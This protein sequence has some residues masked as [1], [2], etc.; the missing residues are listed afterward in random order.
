MSEVRA[1]I[2]LSSSQSQG[3]TEER[4]IRELAGRLRAEFG[5][6]V[7]FGLDRTVP[8]GVP[9]DVRRR[10]DKTEYFILVDFNLDE[11]KE[12]RRNHLWNRSLFAHQEFAIAVYLGLD[13]LAFFEKGLKEPDGIWRYVVKE[14]AR[15]FQRRSL[16]ST[17]LSAVRTQTRMDDSER[18]WSPDWRRELTMSRSTVGTHN[19]GWVQ[20]G[21]A[22]Q[23]KWAKYFLVDV[24]N[25][26]RDL[27]ATDVHAY[28][29]RVVDRSSGLPRVL[30]SLPLKWNALV[31]EST[32][33][34]P[35]TTTGFSGVLMFKDEPGIA[36]VGRN[37][38]LVDTNSY[39]EE[40]RIHPAGSY[41]LHFA[42]FSK[43]FSPA[44]ARLVLKLGRG[45]GETKLV[46]PN[47]DAKLADALSTRYRPVGDPPTAP[48]STLTVSTM[49]FQ[50]VDPWKSD[51]P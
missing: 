15:T 3:S 47:T 50:R 5:F 17:V 21:P 9:D 29:E 14:K 26:H 25:Q 45:P 36:Y 33:I 23:K 30:S 19:T 39:D 35:R 4:A 40:Y 13:Y 2:F 7:T 41:D 48:V 31:T 32:A 42:V 37:P 12:R 20:Y 16:V 28:L 44:R 11:H 46:D 22:H 18:R 8:H 49:D 6:E 10:F 24:S 51:S 34:P 27:T 38:F 43:E 1:R